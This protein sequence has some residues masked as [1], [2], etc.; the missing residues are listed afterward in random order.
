MHL[1]RVLIV[2]GQR[3]QQDRIYPGCDLRL[4]EGPLR[5]SGIVDNIDILYYSDYTPHCDDALLSY[6][7]EKKPQAVLL[8]LQNIGLLGPSFAA[9]RKEGEPTP[10]GLGQITHQLHIPTVAFW[11]DVLIDSTIDVLER[12][13]HS[14][15]L[16]VI[17]GADASSHRPLMP[18]VTNYVYAAD[19]FDE[20]LFDMPEDLRDIPVGFH[21]NIHRN[22]PE[23]VV[24]LRK[25]GIPIYTAEGKLLGGGQEVLSREKD[26]PIWVPYEEYYR[27]TARL[28]MTL[29]FTPSINLKYQPAYSINGE[30]VPIALHWAISKLKMLY[31]GLKLI[32][33]SWRNPLQAVKH[34]ISVLRTSSPVLQPKYQLGSRTWEALWLRT[35]LL[36][37]DNPVISVYFEPYLDYV[38][39]TTLKDLAD[40]IR[41][42][43][44]HEEER[45]RI[46]M[47]GR[48]TVEKY[49]NSRIYWQNLFETIGIQSDMPYHYRPGEIWNK[50][51]LDK[52]YLSHPSIESVWSRRQKIHT[53]CPW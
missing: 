15:T 27:F 21:G 7:L 32:C 53:D 12:Y 5:S 36:E 50:E 34:I 51:Y 4:L 35:F 31:S 48:A 8:S 22:R 37:E 29:N 2:V 45:D 25:F 49:Y 47:H 17:Y 40:K 14:L 28:K 41:Y 24:G 44:E 33:S 52:W 26:T 43:L 16:N 42:Y 1:E 23:W 19:H 11:G 38:P 3:S 46:R 18:E 13:C 39:F 6:C 30:Q 10:D 9:V 20:R